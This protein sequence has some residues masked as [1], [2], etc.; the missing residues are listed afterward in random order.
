[1]KWVLV[2]LILGSMVYIGSILIDFTNYSLRL[3]PHISDLDERAV[4]LCETAEREN[5]TNGEIRDRIITLRD[6]IDSLNG[7]W[8]S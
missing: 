4:D 2:A 7:M 1:M 5:F 6:G 3:K 8:S